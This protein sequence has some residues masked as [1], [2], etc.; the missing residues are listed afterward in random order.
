MN[1]LI[2]NAVKLTLCVCMLIVT[3]GYAFGSVSS[4]SWKYMMGV[5]VAL[6]MGTSAL[7]GFTKK[8]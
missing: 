3:L 5:G 6:H 4:D 7:T 1:E 8:D 2:A